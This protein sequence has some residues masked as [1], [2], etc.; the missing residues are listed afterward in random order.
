MPLDPGDTAFDDRLQ[1]AAAALKMRLPSETRSRLLR[2]LSMIGRWN[3]VYNLTAI[4]STEEMF[5]HHLLDCLAILPSI[6]GWASSRSSP[7]RIL[8]VGSGAGLPGVVLALVRPDWRVTCVDAVSKKA[9]FIRQAQAEL[10]ISNLDA[11]HGRVESA[12]TWGDRQF[13]LIVS[14]AFSSLADFVSMTRQVLADEGDWAAM[15]GV[16]SPDE[17]QSLPADIDMFHVEQIKVPQLDA[18]RCMAW[19]RPSTALSNRT[20]EAYPPAH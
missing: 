20:R 7:P 16:L 15:K 4:Q 12:E 11:V 17:R 13:D 5:T 19:L 6:D 2:H 1:A 3:R 10:A 14:R 18:R 8:D 9:S